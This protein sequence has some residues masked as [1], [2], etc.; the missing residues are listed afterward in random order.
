MGFNY[1]R[2]KK[3]D[4]AVTSDDNAL[5]KNIISDV[6]EALKEDKRNITN[7]EETS[8]DKS[9]GDEAK[10]GDKKIVM[11][12]PHILEPLREIIREQY[13]ELFRTSTSRDKIGNNKELREKILK[14]VVTKYLDDHNYSATHRIYR[15][16]PDGNFEVDENGKR[17]I[18]E[19]EYTRKELVDRL[20]DEMS[21]YSILSSYLHQADVEEINVTCASDVKVIRSG[22]V[23]VETLSESFI[24]AQ[25]ASDT[26]AHLFMENSTVQLDMARNYA[27]TSLTIEGV[28]VR[29]TAAMG[30]IVDREDGVIA[31]I[32]KINPKHMKAEDFIE[33]GTI[34]VDIADFAQGTVQSGISVVLGGATGSGKTTFLECCMLHY[35]SPYDLG[36]M[37]EEDV[38][39]FDL[40]RS[41]NGIPNNIEYLHT[42][43]SSNAA[44][45]VSQ[46]ELI[47]LAMTLHPKYLVPGE[48]KGVESPA[49]L[50]AAL[51][52][53]ATY[54]TIH[55]KNCAGFPSRMISLLQ[56]S[57]PGVAEDTL[58]RMMCE[59]FPI[60]MH[61]IQEKDGTRRCTQIVQNI[62]NEKE[63]R[64]DIRE[65]F[66][67]V[68][69]SEEYD[70]LGNLVKIDG[71]HERVNDLSDDFIESLPYLGATE[72]DIK[73]L[74]SEE[75]YE[76]YCQDKKERIEK[77][78]NRKKAK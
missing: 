51:S 44:T 10:E 31:S 22:S 55:I 63:H 39:E 9:D 34:S 37:I 60:V 5:N 78:L 73:L 26:I 45:S 14:N 13:S 23:R 50:S 52:G 1:F 16:D 64:V 6:K 42:K 25:A 41:I 21:N 38:R 65:L 35:I 11:T 12:L 75:R 53:H 4:V 27:R 61:F 47:E 28:Q 54:T 7:I 48:L 3:P 2:K 77:A 69:T 43:K 29:I 49:A 68:P 56:A 76:K 70:V 74:L 58:Y 30:D 36:I 17:I 20:V 72:K 62:Y 18:D 67:F 15:R 46:T 59:A 57:M 19:I 66:H 24:S 8:K 71:F 40:R 32:R 33:N